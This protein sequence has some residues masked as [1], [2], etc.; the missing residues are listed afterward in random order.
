VRSVLVVGQDKG[1]GSQ[2]PVRAGLW[3]FPYDFSADHSGTAERTVIHRK[4]VTVI[5][6]RRALVATA[7]I[8]AGAALL[9]ATGLFLRLR[10]ILTDS[11]AP[12]GIYRLNAVPVRR[13]ALAAACLPAAIARTGLARGYLAK[14]DCPA[15]A[16]PVA[17]VIGAL[18]G[19]EL[20]IEPG[21]V[22]VNGVKF[23]HS[24]T[25]LRDSA[26]RALAHVLS[27]ARRVGAGEVWLFGFNNR[28]SWDGRYFGP[29]PAMNV[30]G[31]LRPVVTW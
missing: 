25:A 20:Q 6:V 23:P 13:G 15:G 3:P 2:W 12:A 27:G 31:V 1:S 19:D 10:I 17:K 7:I 30:R 9:V 22:A 4:W 18:P 8:I 11:A 21:F 29:V 16:E 28:R 14:G 24:Q 26:G 5:R